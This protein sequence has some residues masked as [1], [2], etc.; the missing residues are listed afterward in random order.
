MG[1]RGR[2]HVMVASLPLHRILD[3]DRADRLAPRASPSDG[4]RPRSEATPARNRAVERIL[5][6]END[7]SVA[8]GSACGDTQRDGL[9]RNRCDA[10]RGDD[11]GLVEDGPRLV[12]LSHD[13]GSHP[14]L[15]SATTRPK[16]PR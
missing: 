8:N 1:T 5:E 12:V 14:N 7:P 13:P 16:R 4:Y 10:Q 11:H 3:R 6:V 15:L 2:P 9:P